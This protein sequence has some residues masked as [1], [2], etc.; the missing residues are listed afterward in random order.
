MPAL[1][2]CQL[3]HF[4]A[5]AHESSLTKVAER[6]HVSPSAL[7]IQLHSP[8]DG[9]GHPLFIRENR[10]LSLAERDGWR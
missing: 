2:D 8:E 5:I 10:R 4:R 6:L 9:L 7:S 3:R 1:N